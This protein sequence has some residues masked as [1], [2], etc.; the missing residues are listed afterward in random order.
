MAKK[1]LCMITPLIMTLDQS[2]N[3]SY[4]I[5]DRGN[6]LRTLLK[7]RNKVNIPTNLNDIPMLI[8]RSMGTQ[9]ENLSRYRLCKLGPR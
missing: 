2:D 1:N 6:H 7:I 4:S 9:N 5:G 8:N 3:Q